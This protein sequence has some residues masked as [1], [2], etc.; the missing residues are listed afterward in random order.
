MVLLWWCL[1]LLV[2]WCRFWSLCCWFGRC[3]LNCWMSWVGWKV[4]FI[5]CVV[6]WMRLIVVCCVRFFG[7]WLVLVEFGSFLMI[8]IWW[9][10]WLVVFGFCFELFVFGIVV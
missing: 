4:G 6:C 2:L 10:V 5:C 3:V 7:N 9:V 1:F 8:V